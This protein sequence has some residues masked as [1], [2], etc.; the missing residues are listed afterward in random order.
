M[1]PD[2]SN[3]WAGL[4]FGVITLTGLHSTCKQPSPLCAAAVSQGQIL[5]GMQKP[6]EPTLQLGD[7]GVSAV[8]PDWLLRGEQTGLTG[9]RGLRIPA[10]IAPTSTWETGILTG[11]WPLLPGSKHNL[12]HL[13][14]ALW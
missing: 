10:Q 9:G 11:A 14:H 12:T 4:G 1:V 6:Q 8:E 5:Q 7:N 13:L 2:C 3:P